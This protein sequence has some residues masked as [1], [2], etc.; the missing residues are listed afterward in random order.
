MTNSASRSC[1]KAAISW[2][3]S[4]RN[5]GRRSCTRPSDTGTSSSVITASRSD[6]TTTLRNP[7]LGSRIAER[8]PDEWPAPKPQ[9]GHDQPQLALRRAAMN[10]RQLHLYVRTKGLLSPHVVECRL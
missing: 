10:S 8:S 6:T 3:L 2:V 1:W 5:A 9:L 4:S 7:E